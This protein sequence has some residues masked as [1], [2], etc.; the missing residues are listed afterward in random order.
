MQTK[1]FEIPLL[2]VAGLTSADADVKTE[3]DSPAP[4]FHQR[5]AVS[6]LWSAIDDLPAEKGEQVL[7]VKGQPGTGKSTAIW[8]KVLEG[9]GWLQDISLKLDG[10]RPKAAVYF[11]G[12][13]YYKFTELPMDSLVS[14]FYVLRDPFGYD[15]R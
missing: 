8:R 6:E 15:R 5:S 1:L 11:Q 7:F 14:C 2:D 4:V 13:L 9:S 10:S 12:R 3:Q